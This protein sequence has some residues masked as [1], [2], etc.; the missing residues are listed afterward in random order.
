MPDTTYLVAAVL[1]SAAVTWTL[2]ALP[3]AALAPL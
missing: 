3:F 1:I 2:R